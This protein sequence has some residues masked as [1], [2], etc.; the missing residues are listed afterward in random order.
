VIPILE[1]L[2]GRIIS[3]A[4]FDDVET[5]GQR[6]GEIHGRSAE[7]F[8]DHRVPRRIQELHSGPDGGVG[9]AVGRLCVHVKMDSL[10]KGHVDRAEPRR[11]TAPL[12]RAARG[13]PETMYLEY[14]K[15]LTGAV[16]KRPAVR[17]G[18]D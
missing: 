18:S 7:L 1:I 5:R 12:D 4:H 10:R 13:R 3:A 9:A 11:Q 6:L 8:C 17:G 15:K 2:D 14:R 16:A